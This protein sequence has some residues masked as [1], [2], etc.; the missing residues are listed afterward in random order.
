MAVKTGLPLLAILCGACATGGGG[1]RGEGGNEYLTLRT[2]GATRQM[3]IEPSGRVFGADFELASTDTGYQGTVGGEVASMMVMEGQHVV[4][5]RGSQRIDLHVTTDGNNILATGM[6]GG[7][8][9]RLQLGAE[10]ISSSVGRCSVVVSRKQERI[11]VGQQVCR[12]GMPRFVHAEIELP[13]IFEQLEPTRRVM[14]LAALV[15]G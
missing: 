6:Y 2:E 11:Y 7:M 14:L 10:K 13:P 4:G 5:S 1:T 3:K 8:M 15:S 12:G 9:G